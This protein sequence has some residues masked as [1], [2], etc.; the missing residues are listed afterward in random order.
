[1]KLKMGMSLQKKFNLTFL[2]KIEKKCG[3]LPFENLFT[4]YKNY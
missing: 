3:H 2:C 1:M 4:N